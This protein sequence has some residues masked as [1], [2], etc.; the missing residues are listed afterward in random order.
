LIEVEPNPQEDDQSISLPQVT[1]EFN[2]ISTP[3]TIQQ[4]FSDGGIL[5]LRHLTWSKF[6]DLLTDVNHLFPDFQDNYLNQMS[7]H[8]CSRDEYLNKFTRGV[9]IL[10]RE[11][12]YLT[13][14][15]LPRFSITLQTN[16]TPTSSTTGSLSKS[17]TILASNK[18]VMWK[19]VCEIRRRFSFLER[20]NDN[21]SEG[22]SELWFNQMYSRYYWPEPENPIFDP[23]TVQVKYYHNNN[24]YSCECTLTFGHI[25]LS[26]ISGELIRVPIQDIDSLLVGGEFSAPQPYDLR[27]DLISGQIDLQTFTEAKLRAKSRTEHYRELS[28][29][30]TGNGSQFFGMLNAFKKNILSASPEETSALY[31]D[32]LG[33]SFVCTQTV[34]GFSPVWNSSTLFKISEQILHS[35]NNENGGDPVGMMF[36][37]VSPQDSCVLGSKFVKFSDLIPKLDGFAKNVQDTDLNLPG[38]TK[39]LVLDHTIELDQDVAIRVDVLHA[40]GLPPDH[41]FKVVCSFAKFDGNIRKKYSQYLYD[42]LLPSPPSRNTKTSLSSGQNLFPVLSLGIKHLS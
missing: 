9:K 30:T 12:I 23:I 33:G 15:P 22:R 28:G 19:I 42:P 39:S 29:R 40:R 41:N 37:L 3:S 8:H 13:S 34:P 32:L 6:R 17:I 35:R 24:F 7:P 10:L 14:I 2:E 4:A 38:G 16:A 27:M 11:H 20:Q 26:M 31:V 18:F 21:L 25:E 36:H 1:K 5:Q